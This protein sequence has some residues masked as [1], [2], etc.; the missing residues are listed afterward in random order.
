MKTP[1]NPTGETPDSLKQPAGGAPKNKLNLTL[2]IAPDLMQLLCVMGP[3][4]NLV[5]SH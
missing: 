2:G 1:Q 4:M 3:C 5:L